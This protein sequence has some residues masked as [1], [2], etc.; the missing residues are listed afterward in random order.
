MAVTNFELSSNGTNGIPIDITK[1]TK[2]SITYALNTGSKWIYSNYPEYM[3][4]DSFIDTNFG[5][6]YLNRVEVPAGTHRIFYS[7]FN[8]GVYAA[9]PLPFTIG[10]R[11]Y[12][13]SG[14]LNL[15]VNKYG[16]AHSYVNGGGNDYCYTAAMAWKMF[17]DTAP[18]TANNLSNF[19]VGSTWICKQVIQYNGWFTGVIDFYVS[20]ACAITVAAFKNQANASDSPSP[21]P[22]LIGTVGSYNPRKMYSGEA[23]GNSY[24][25]N[26]SLDVASIPVETY[27]WI[28]TCQDS[29]GISITGTGNIVPAGTD[30]LPILK[31]APKQNQ[32]AVE[33]AATMKPLNTN[34]TPTAEDKNIGNWH[35]EYNYN[36]SLTN[37]GGSDR[38]IK[39]YVQTTHTVADGGKCYSI[40]RQGSTLTW[41]NLPSGSLNAWRFL[42][43]RI[44][45]GS[46]VAYSLPFKLILG[47]N[48]SIPMNLLYKTEV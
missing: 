24:T 46:T 28:P 9:Q 30:L 47:T 31:I 38:T 42:S 26:I 27:Q 19:G 39:F 45:A 44:S 36:F 20:K 2:K 21:Y 8:G 10:I 23:I 35:L 14:T 13:S 29:S 25:A 5:A 43:L 34:Y 16:T 37:S 15:I 33:Y 22:L 40:V 32:S 4:S 6:K 12:N 3:Q 7:H 11:V 1:A 48:A 41:Y 17:Y 18:G